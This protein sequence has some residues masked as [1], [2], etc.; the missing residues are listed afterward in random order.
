MSYE[1]LLTDRCS[2]YHL[3]KEQE[4]SS[5]GVPGETKYEYPANPDLLDIPCL[6]GKSSQKIYNSEPGVVFIET[7]LV[8]FFI[9]TDVRFND[10]VIFNGTTYRLD[11]P[12]NI[13]SHHIEV[14]AVRDDSI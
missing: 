1:N 7:F 4:T 13:R 9:G 8:H 14:T 10:K 2:V 6:F 5:Y 3:I 11:V 12:R